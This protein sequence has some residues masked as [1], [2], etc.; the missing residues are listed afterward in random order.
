M[1]DFDRLR[2]DDQLVLEWNFFGKKYPTA[3]TPADVRTL[4]MHE[5]VWSIWQKD[6]WNKVDLYH[7]GKA[8]T[9]LWNYVTDQSQRCI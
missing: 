6:S 5:H 3:K 1:H 4:D 9:S 7:V 2:V 8:D